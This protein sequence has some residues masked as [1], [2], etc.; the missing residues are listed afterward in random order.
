MKPCTRIE[1]ATAS[2]V[3]LLVS[4]YRRPAAARYL[5]RLAAHVK[6]TGARATVYSALKSN[7][8]ACFV[9]SNGRRGRLDRAMTNTSRLAD[10][11]ASP[12]QRK[13]CESE[14]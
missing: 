12:D 6:T 10:E 1:L 9:R 13:T 14:A 7:W 3:A 11:S 4:H 8:R 2:L 5:E